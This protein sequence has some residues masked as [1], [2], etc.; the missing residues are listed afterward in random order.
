M[1]AITL[2][3][4]VE[5]LPVAVAVPVNGLLM[6]LLHIACAAVTGERKKPRSTMRKPLSS[7]R[8]HE[9]VGETDELVGKSALR[10]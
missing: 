5:L 8:T 6:L 9:L 3:I 10:Q 7:Y 1:K 2:P 4:H